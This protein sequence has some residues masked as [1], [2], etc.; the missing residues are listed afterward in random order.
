MSSLPELSAKKTISRPL[1]DVTWNGS[2]LILHTSPNGPS[3]PLS[4][5]SNVLY[6]KL[7]DC[8]VASSDVRVAPRTT[9]VSRCVPVQ[10][11]S[12]LW[13]PETAD[14]RV[15][16]RVSVVPN[17]GPG[18]LTPGGLTGRSLGIHNVPPYACMLLLQRNSTLSIVVRRSR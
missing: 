10:R 3:V 4:A 6:L 11:T 14:V 18:R 2:I 17:R 7:V 1:A 15:D 13:R 9:D 16:A 5:D 8:M 12:G